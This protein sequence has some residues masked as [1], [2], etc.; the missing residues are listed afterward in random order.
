MITQKQILM[1]LRVEKRSILR[2]NLG[3]VRLKFGLEELSFFLWAVAWHNATQRSFK[4]LWEQDDRGLG[5]AGFM[6]NVQTASRLWPIVFRRSCESMGIRAS[7]LY[8]L[9]R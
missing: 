8:N 6:K 4:R 7:S 3:R 5:Y 2:A 9:S 1:W